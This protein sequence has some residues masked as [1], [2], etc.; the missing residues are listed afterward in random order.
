MG[1][2]E[3]YLVRVSKL[4]HP[5]D[6]KCIYASA[7]FQYHGAHNA[8]SIEEAG[9]QAWIAMRYRHPSITCTV[10]IPEKT[11]EY[12]CP[13]SE[14]D[15]E[16]WVSS[17]FSITNLEFSSI[18]RQAKTLPLATLYFNPESQ[19]VLLQT[20]H[21]RFDGRGILLFFDTFFDAF[22]NP[23][24]QPVTF[25]D[26]YIRLSLLLDALAGFPDPS[27]ANAAAE[28]DAVVDSFL[29]AQPSLGLEQRANVEGQWLGSDAV[30]MTFSPDE[31]AALIQGAKKR[32]V[33]VTQA[34]QAATYMAIAA[35]ASNDDQN[36]Q[37]RGKIASMTIVD[38]RPWCGEH[39]TQTPVSC[40][41][42]GI[43]TVIELGE[44]DDITQQLGEQWKKWVRTDLFKDGVA[45]YRDRFLPITSQ[46]MPFLPST[47]FVTSMGIADT[48]L[49]REHGDGDRKLTVTDYC[50]ADERV[51]R[52]LVVFVWTFNDR[53]EINLAYNSGYLER[54]FVE[55]FGQTLKTQL[56]RGLHL[57]AN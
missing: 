31:T 53:L 21:W 55:S 36:Q 22:T 52:E 10:N 28:I 34:V 38:L 23:S 20:S 45:Q 3:T 41:F 17:T 33:T 50:I 48:Y 43:M 4:S 27:P 47:P 54:E 18:I 19:S 9:R 24:P 16:S 56:Y 6:E 51:G 2:G 26:E 42:G 1:F 39:A 30:R 8:A 12:R 14:G 40:Y 46:P 57:T 44:F 15:V 29:A 37:G 35:A 25:G 13:V 5:H 7:S 49:K 32:N 11:F